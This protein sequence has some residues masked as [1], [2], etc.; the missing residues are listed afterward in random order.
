MTTFV[1]LLRG[2]NVGK[3]RRVPMAGFRALLSG[4]GYTDV[5]TL[6]NSG[7]AVFRSGKG[8]SAGHAA[9]IEQALADKMKVETP[10]VV[11]SAKELDAV[12]AENPLE[13]EAAEY[14]RLLVAYAQGQPALEG[15]AAIRPFVVSPEQFAIG[16]HAAYLLCTRGILQSKAAEA[17]LGKARLAV[18]TRNW[19][20][21]L[22]LQSLANERDA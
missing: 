20:T 3:A 6:L 7:N 16:R 1:A 21:T 10:V 22:K 13:V 14:A 19:V 18:T 4:L 17:L 11:M 9:H 12:V 8:S 5:V 2:V 15:L